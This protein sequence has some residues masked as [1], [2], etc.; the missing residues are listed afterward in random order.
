MK[1]TIGE[2]TTRKILIAAGILVALAMMASLY[3]SYQR[4]QRLREGSRII[5]EYDPK[6]GKKVPA[7]Y[8]EPCEHQINIEDC[9]HD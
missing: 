9:L 8:A 3:M 7:I 5:M 4:I 6:T 1:R 2:R